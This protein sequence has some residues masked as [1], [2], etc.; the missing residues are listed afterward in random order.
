MRG[1]GGGRPDMHVPLMAFKDNATKEECEASIPY[2]IS[3]YLRLLDWTGR[4]VHPDKRGA[5]DDE[6][7][8]IIQRLGID[9]AAW[10]LAM[11]PHGN[12]FGR[13]MGRLDAL[14]LHAKTLGQSWVQGLRQAE[15]MYCR[16]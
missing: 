7:P 15:R 14:R 11:R 12:V 3:D 5:I 10:T 8:P 9:A 13:A 16:P 2:C 4:I 1:A 6:L